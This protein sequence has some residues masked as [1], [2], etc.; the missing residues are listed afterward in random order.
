MKTSLIVDF[1]LCGEVVC[2]EENCTH[3]FVCI[4]W[5]SVVWSVRKHLL[6][7][8]NLPGVKTRLRCGI[9]RTNIAKLVKQHQCLKSIDLYVPATHCLWKCDPCSITFHSEASLRNHLAAHK[10]AALR[11]AAPK[12][13]LPTPSIKKRNRRKRGAKVSSD[14]NDPSTVSDPA[15]V[16]AQPVLQ[17]DIHVRPDETVQGPLAHFLD[18]LDIFL[19]DQFSANTFGAF[20][21]LVEDITQAAITHLFPD[22]PPSNGTSSQAIAINVDDPATCQRLYTRN[23]RRTVREIVGNVGERCKIPL[24]NLALP[25]SAIFNALRCNGVGETLV[26]LVEDIYTAS[27]TSILTEEG[28]SPYI[29]ISSGVKQGCPLSGLLF[30][31]AIDPVLRK[32]RALA[33]HTKSLPLRTTSVF[34]LTRPMSCSWD[35][36]KFNSSSG[37]FIS[38]LTRASPF[39]STS[40][41]LHLLGYLTLSSSLVPTGLPLME[42]EFHRFLGKPVGFNPVPDYS[43]INDLAELGAKLARSKLTPWQRIDSLKSFFLPLPSVPHED[44]SISQRSTRLGRLPD[45]ATIGA[46]LSGEVEGEFSTSSNRYSN[47]WTVARVASR[48]LGIC[49]T[50][51]DSSPFLSFADLTLKANSRRK[52]LFSIRDRLRTTRSTALLQKINQGKWLA[53]PQPAPTSSP[54]GPTLGSL[55]GDLSIVLV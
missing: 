13:S 50:F 2:P 41:G 51:E 48:R 1:P 9:C 7:H 6:I 4:S 3:S 40:M 26:R 19:A 29:P 21:D 20:E 42:G 47:T 54:M 14:I 28:V 36:T 49:W 37:N 39:L 45:D 25:H 16:L 11:D 8:H 23:R 44:G 43:S 38:I 33:H 35:L 27:S 31:I 24:D 34:L 53:S 22:G 12:L 46:F 52:I 18:P 55:I 15:A 32:F 5:S 17:K 10:K 30:N